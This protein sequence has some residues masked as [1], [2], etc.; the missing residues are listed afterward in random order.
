MMPTVYGELE[1]G[2]SAAQVYAYLRDRYKTDVFRSV[3][4][5]VKGYV[6]EIQCVD[7]Q[8]N[9]RL[10]F[11]VAAQDVLLRI[12][13]GNWVWT[14]ELTRL[15]DDKTKVSITYEWSV[16]LSL[17]SMFT[18]RHQA[19]NELIETALALDALAANNKLKATQ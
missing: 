18:I 3:C 8:E 9:E 11:S 14:Y 5:M 12:K 13:T 19:V 2:C 10:S 1:I 16:L 17:F 4:M 15:E 6:P 7:E